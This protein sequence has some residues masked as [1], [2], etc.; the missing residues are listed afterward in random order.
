MPNST[1]QAL[2]SLVYFGLNDVPSSI[3]GQVIFDLIDQA[4]L[5]SQNITRQT[6]GSNAVPDAYQS[7]IINLTKAWTLA[8]MSQVGASFNW[9]LGEFS[10]NKGAGTNVEATQVQMFFDMAML[11]LK[12]ISR[13]L[14]FDKSNG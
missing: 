12:N 2:G 11:E 8:R 10:V 6:I 7:P 1:H 3:S 4:R 13:P 9:N 5:F 14:R